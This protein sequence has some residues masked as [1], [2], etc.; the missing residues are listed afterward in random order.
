MI[1]NLCE[2]VKS[3]PKTTYLSI[4]RRMM[5]VQIIKIYASKYNYYFYHM[6]IVD[7]MMIIIIRV[8]MMTLWSGY[9]QQKMLITGTI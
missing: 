7:E 5:A 3:H 2:E 1:V 4:I 8:A 9:A 6:Q